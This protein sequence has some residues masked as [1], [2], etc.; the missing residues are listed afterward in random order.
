M[1]KNVEIKIRDGNVMVTDKSKVLFCMKK[2]K[3]TID[4]ANSIYMYHRYGEGK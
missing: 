2:T 3:Q 1:N 4:I